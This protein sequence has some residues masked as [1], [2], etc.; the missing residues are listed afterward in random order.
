MAEICYLERAL[1]ILGDPGTGKSTQLRSLFL[2]QRFGKN[3]VIPKQRRVPETYFISNERRLYL[4]LTSPHESRESLDGFL[5]KC[6][7]KMWSPSREVSR[8]NFAGPLQIVST[9]KQIIPDGIDVIKGFMNR[10]KPERVRVVFFSPDCFGNFLGSNTLQK[11]FVELHKMDCEVIL[12]DA[13]TRDMNGLL[14][15]DFFDF[16]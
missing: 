13:R 9:N 15:S 16:T 5:D 8:W 2:D 10:F 14:Y 11:H 4:R 1:F 3:G 6:E 7:S 12:T